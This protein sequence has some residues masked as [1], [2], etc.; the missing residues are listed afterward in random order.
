MKK[1][2]ITDKR[3]AEVVTVPD[4]VAKEN[5]AV[6]K[7]HTAPMCTEYKSFLSGGP[8]ANLGH[9][10]AGEVVEVAQP[11]RVKVGDRVAVMPQT[12]CGCCELCLSGEYIHCQDV[13]DFESFFGSLDG[14]ATYAQYVAKPD[15]LLVPIPDN[16]SYDHGSMAC[17]GLGPTFGAFERIGLQSTDTVLITGLGPVGL[18][19][20]ITATHFG[21][22]VIGVDANQY[23]ANL[24]QELGAEAVIDPTDPDA[25][26][27]ICSLTYDGRGVDHVVDCSGVPAAHRLGIDAARRKG[28]VSFVGESGNQETSL[29]VSKDMIRK[30]LTLYGS[31][32]YNRKDTGKLMRI[33]EANGPK[34]D[35]QIS[36]VFPL[37]KVQDAFELQ[38]TGE[39]AKVLLKP[40][41]EA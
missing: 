10:A 17:C 7:I 13:T 19:G 21:A 22:R 31:W 24:A 40:W 11:G 4:P 5:W 27:Q 3:Q 33:I 6:V 15:W 35:K 37:D 30:G 20:V 36:H 9:E 28:T 29:Q 26:A 2:V 16:V 18:G 34:L 1:V 8:A 23:R 12:S 14:S 39:S 25:L 38:A 32:H 41:I